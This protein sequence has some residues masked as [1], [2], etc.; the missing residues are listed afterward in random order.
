[1]FFRDK[2][3]LIIGG[4]GTIGQSLV[5]KILE[6]QPRV[7][8]I[9]SRDEYK[10]FELANRMKHSENR[11]R[12]LIGDVRNYDRVYSAM[13]DIDYVFHVAAMKHVPACEYNPYEAVLT[14]IVGTNNVIKAAIAQ[15]VQ[16]VVF[17][18][19]DKAISPT[20]IYGATK[21]AAEKLVISAEY[22]KGTSGTIFSMVRFGNVMG[23]RGS[24]IPLFRQQILESRKVTVTDLSMSRFMMTLNQA[25][26]L[27]IRAMQESKGGE[28]FVLKMPVISLHDLV[29]A[30]I[31]ET[32][33]KYGINPG[34]VQM[35]EIGLRSGEKKFEE[36][37]TYEESDSAWELPDM[38]IIP[39]KFSNVHQ[40]P[41]AIKTT[42]KEYDS[43]TEQ[44]ISLEEVRRLILDE[45][46]V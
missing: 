11:L 43:Q 18:S 6:E 13:Q 45:K 3:I 2:K 21:L 38:F 24:V 31:E 36:L 12:F 7:I 44:P 9:Y 28:I 40:Y 34:D 4:T 15:N 23:S 5:R 19:S 10:Q 42:P 33:K 39:S 16:R 27:T 25:T 29:T 8:R 26:S 41:H 1:M 35:E 37:M 30:V 22:S 20:N 14:N 32:C 46:I 17:T